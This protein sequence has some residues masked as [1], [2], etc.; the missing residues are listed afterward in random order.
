MV[1]RYRKKSSISLIAS[2]TRKLYYRDLPAFTA[3]GIAPS[4]AE[5]GTESTAY[6]GTFAVPGWSPLSTHIYWYQPCTRKKKTPPFFPLPFSSLFSFPILP[7]LSLL[8]LL[9][10]IFPFHTFTMGSLANGSQPGT[11]LFTSESV[12]EGHPD[13]IA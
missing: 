11:F 12:G 2:V 1:K 5:R 6:I 4:R 10:F 3:L 8:F 7:S 9:L 13:K